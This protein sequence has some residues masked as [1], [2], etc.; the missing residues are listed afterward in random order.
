[1][2]EE[3]IK[4]ETA[5]LAKEKGFD[6]NTYSECWVK[7][8]DGK[9]IHNSERED[10]P[11]HD[12]CEVLYMQP[13]QSLLQKW[14]RETYNIDVELFS[15]THNNIKWW[16]VYVKIGTSVQWNPAQLQNENQQYKKYEI[17][18]EEG[19]QEALKLIKII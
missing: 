12:R 9:V 18:L 11:E 7:T 6:I 13:T 4:I 2:E 17:A 10:I 16:R 8:L 19:L 14:L 5:K 15:V 3:L 1:M